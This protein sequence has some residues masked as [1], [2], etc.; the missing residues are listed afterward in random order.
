MN[1]SAEP[2]P[3]RRILIV[4]DDV[5]LVEGLE[6]TFRSAG[7]TATACSSFELARQLLRS[8]EYD[9]LITD[10]RLGAFNGLQLALLARDLYPRITLIVF[11][12][13]D[14]PVLRAEAEHA[15]AT[16]VV[17]PVATSELLELARRPPAA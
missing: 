11:S 3:P 9:V 15:G 10:V 2:R 16:Y 14:D 1:T 12:G 5:A 6:S 17:K 4:D 13:F 8:G 7:E